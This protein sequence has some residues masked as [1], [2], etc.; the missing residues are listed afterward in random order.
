MYICSYKINVYTW[1]LA[2]G[3]W[4]ENDASPHRMVILIYPK[5]G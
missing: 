1:V 5:V 4:A 2:S 3:T